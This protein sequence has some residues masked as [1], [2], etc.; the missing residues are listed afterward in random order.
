MTALAMG[1]AT[2]PPVASLPRSPPS[3]TITA[4]AMR[5]GALSLGPAKAV[6]QALGGVAQLGSVPQFVEVPVFPATTHPGICA[7]VPVPLWT[8]EII[9]CRIWLAVSG[10][11]G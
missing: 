1:A 2:R 8:T 6:N 7:S 10:E 5:G 9:I 4:T 11:I 3:M